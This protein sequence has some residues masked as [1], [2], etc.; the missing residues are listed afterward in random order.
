MLLESGDPASIVTAALDAAAEP[1]ERGALERRALLSPAELDEGLTAAV[2]AGD[3]YLTQDRLAELRAEVGAAL[4]ARAAASPLDPGIP[5]A[6]LLPQRPWASAVLPLL[7]LERR[8]AKAYAPGASARLGD[9]A[10]AAAAL[11]AELTTAGLATVKADDRELAAYLEEQGRLVRLG[12]GFAIGAQAYE[13]GAQ[14]G[15]GRVRGERARSPSHDSATSRRT[16]RRA[17]QLI[18]E[19]LD[20]DGVTRRAGDSRV[21]RRRA[22]EGATPSKETAPPGESGAV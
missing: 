10:D 14:P 5:I 7:P 13:R 18:L 4:A 21:L 2:A 8:G 15:L 17:A 1:L 6:E 11:E 16:N 9:R 19:R 20:S 12:D 3:W 22:R